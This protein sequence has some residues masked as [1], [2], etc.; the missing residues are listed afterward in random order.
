MKV[1]ELSGAKLD[2]WVA[3]AFGIDVTIVGNECHEVDGGYLMGE[4]SPSLEWS[5][6][7]LIIEREKIT[8]E[9]NPYGLDEWSACIELKGEEPSW[10]W[11]SGESA[12]IS[13]MR[14]YVAS[15]FGLEVA[16][17]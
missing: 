5:Q 2:Y 1:S 15:K 17:E 11:H 10:V 12:L 8:I 3:R 7:G 14:V 13:A 4:F 6:G 16:D 9:P